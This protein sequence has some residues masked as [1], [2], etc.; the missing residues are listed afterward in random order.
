MHVEVQFPPSSCVFCRL[1][2][3]LHW[4]SLPQIETLCPHNTF[5]YAFFFRPS[6]TVKFLMAPRYLFNNCCPNQWRPPSKPREN[7]KHSIFNS[8]HFDQDYLMKTH[9]HHH[10][11]SVNRKNPTFS[12]FLP[13]FLRKFMKA[14][15]CHTRISHSSVAS[16]STHRF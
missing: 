2:S 12:H 1:F 10:K 14:N 13:A 11:Q 15:I 16:S 8:L 5:L 3:N 9:P 4:E 7:N 6:R